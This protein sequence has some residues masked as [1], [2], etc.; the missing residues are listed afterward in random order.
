MLTEK[1]I[2]DSMAKAKKLRE[3]GLLECKTES[4]ESRICA[5]F[6]LFGCDVWVPCDDVEP[7]NWRTEKFRE[8]TDYVKSVV[9]QLQK[10]KELADQIAETCT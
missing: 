2:Q 6:N 7:L 8:M 1:E 5:L 9:D 3:A 10:I 4:G